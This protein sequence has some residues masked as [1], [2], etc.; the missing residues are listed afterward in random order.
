MEVRDRSLTPPTPLNLPLRGLFG[1]SQ[2]G[3]LKTKAPAWHALLTLMPCTIPCSL[4]ICLFLSPSFPCWSWRR[5]AGELWRQHDWLCSLHPSGRMGVYQNVIASLLHLDSSQD[6]PHPP[7]S[8]H[9]PSLSLSLHSSPTL[10]SLREELWRPRTCT[11]C[12]H[13]CPSGLAS[14]LQVLPGLLLVLI[15]AWLHLVWVC[16][17]PGKTPSCHAIWTSL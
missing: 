6:A 8:S 7:P 1:L 13:K 9:L 16:G 12:L 3:T 10:F 15:L 11:S 4:S 17:W 14:L 2:S 5:W